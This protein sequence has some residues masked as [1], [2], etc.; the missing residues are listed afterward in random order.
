MGKILYPVGT[1]VTLRKFPRVEGLYVTRYVKGEKYPYRV[2]LYPGDEINIE[3]K[4]KFSV[5]GLKRYQ[6]PTEKDCPVQ[7][8][9]EKDYYTRDEVNKLLSAQFEDIS[10]LVDLLRE[11]LGSQVLH[12]ANVTDRNFMRFGKALKTLNHDDD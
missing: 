6:K 12:V 9:A 10:Y 8:P 2:G 4:S 3:G 7:S 5:K 11:E 1:A